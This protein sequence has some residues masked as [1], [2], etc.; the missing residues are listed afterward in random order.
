[1]QYI[2]KGQSKSRARR[3]CSIVVC[4]PPPPRRLFPL[5]D[6]LYLLLDVVD[7]VGSSIRWAQSL[8]VGFCPPLL[9]STLRHWVLPSVIGFC[10]PPLGSTPVVRFYLLP[11]I[12]GPCPCGICYAAWWSPRRSLCRVVLPTLAALL[13]MWLFVPLFA[14]PVFAVVTVIH[15][16]LGVA[17]CRDGTC[18]VILE[19]VLLSSNLYCCRRTS[20]TVVQPESPS[21]EPLILAWL[22]VVEGGFP[23]PA[24]GSPHPDV[25]RCAGIR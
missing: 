9:G 3:P 23:T 1:M 16:V 6:A 11:F 14:T 10:P 15:V 20:I 25:V 17:C 8:V 4:P 13:P 21:I 2:F 22:P 5:P 19:P 24:L 18:I 12:I 7:L